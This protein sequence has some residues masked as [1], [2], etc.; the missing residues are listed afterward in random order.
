[1]II[2]SPMFARTG[3]S[4]ELNYDE[5]FHTYLILI[6]SEKCKRKSELVKI[7]YIKIHLEL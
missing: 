4:D 5:C 3:F 2:L 6:F 1:M 7:F